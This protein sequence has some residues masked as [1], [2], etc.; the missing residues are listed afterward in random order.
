MLL[1]R[2]H[3]APEN[4]IPLI[5]AAFETTNKDLLDSSINTDL[6]GSTVVAVFI[7][8]G[9]IYCFNVGDSRAV[10]FNCK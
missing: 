1:R 6:S 4:I 8:C 7:Y 9:K 2:T 3:E 5:E 10:L